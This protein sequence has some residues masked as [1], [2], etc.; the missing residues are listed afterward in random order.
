MDVGSYL[1][2]VKVNN[3]IVPLYQYAALDKAYLQV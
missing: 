3:V 2:R 1:V